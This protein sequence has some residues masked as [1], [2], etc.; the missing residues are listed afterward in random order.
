LQDFWFPLHLFCLAYNNHHMPNLIDDITF[1]T[2][3]YSPYN[4]KKEK[5]IIGVHMDILC[6]ILKR[7]N[8]NTTR[9][10]VRLVPWARGYKIIQNSENI[11]LFRMARIQKREHR[12]KWAGPI[13]E[14]QT[15]A[16]SKNTSGITIQDIDDLKK[17]KIGV[18]KEDIAGKILMSKGISANNIFPSYGTNAEKEIILE[19]DN[20]IIDLWVFG[21]LPARWLIHQDYKAVYTLLRNQSFFAFS[22]DVNDKLISRFQDELNGIKKDGTYKKIIPAYLSV[23]WVNKTNLTVDFLFQFFQKL[24]KGIFFKHLSNLR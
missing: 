11:W 7:M 4:F 18:V 22:K 1:I 5:K 24:I 14:E 16:I 13:I 21:K 9:Y 10:S 3:N 8:S 17:Y 12:F 23:H 15:V 19:L 20:G 6:E 2:E